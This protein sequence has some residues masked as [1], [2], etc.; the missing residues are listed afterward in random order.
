[1]RQKKKEKS[2]HIGTVAVAVAAKDFSLDRIVII[3][4]MG[5]RMV[6]LLA[7]ISGVADASDFN[8]TAGSMAVSLNEYQ[9]IS[10]LQTLKDPFDFAP[11]STVGLSHRLGDV[12]LSVR[13]AGA[14]P[15]TPYITA[16]TAR[17]ENRVHN[18]LPPPK[19][20]FA[21]ATVGFERLPNLTLTRHWS[22]A[23]KDSGLRM[24]FELTNDGDAVE[25]GSFGA[26]MI[27]MTKSVGGG[28]SLD[29]MAAT[30]AMVDPAIE[31]EVSF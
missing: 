11:P 4:K 23:P 28:K 31:G 19:G 24:W 21:A 29:D 17:N 15:S 26:A 8:F 18:I 6:L 12:T 30:C 9:T 1:M 27:F 20:D 16:T 22:A 13:P 3:R 14:V 2:G 10:S 7:A 5:K 25:I